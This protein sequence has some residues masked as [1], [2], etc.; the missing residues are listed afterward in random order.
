MNNFTL[1][2][3]QAQRCMGQCGGKRK[4]RIGLKDASSVCVPSLTCS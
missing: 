2:W 3:V 1:M 4:D